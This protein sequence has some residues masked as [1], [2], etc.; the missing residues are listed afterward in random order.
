MT[1]RLALGCAVLCAGLWLWTG[2]ARAAEPGTLEECYLRVAIEKSTAD[3]AYVA[4]EICDAVFR[5]FPRPVTVRDPRTRRCVEWWFDERGR[6]ESAQRVCALTSAA[7]GLWQFAC[8]AKT[9]DGFTFAEL[10]EVGGRYEPV[11]PVH[12]T[13]VGDL[14][15][16]LPACI[17][18]RL[19]GKR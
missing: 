10:R 13:A 4:R 3:L 1:V 7:D 5:R 15:T 16:G 9:G 19:D 6:Y 17:E 8:Q 14:F 2:S 18:S 11:G 12:G